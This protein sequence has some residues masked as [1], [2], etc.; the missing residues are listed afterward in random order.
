MADVTDEA[1]LDDARKRFDAIWWA[2]TLIWMGLALAAGYFDILPEVGDSNEWWPWIFIGVAP[3]S[4]ALSLYRLVSE[5]AP[6]PSAWDWTWTGVFTAVA[7]GA[8]VDISGAL[9]GAIALVITGVV[10][11]ARARPSVR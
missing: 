8:F 9:V 3:W 1:A 6:N 10:I 4:I 11:L 2:G 7:L 5:N